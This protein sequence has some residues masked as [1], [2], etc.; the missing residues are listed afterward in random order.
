[1]RLVPLRTGDAVCGGEDWIELYNAEAAAADL[2]GGAVQVE[3]C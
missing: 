3:L 2:T 1:M